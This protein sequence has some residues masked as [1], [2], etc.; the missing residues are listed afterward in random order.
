M[1]QLSIKDVVKKV[2]EKSN[3]ILFKSQLRMVT[4]KPFGKFRTTVYEG[5]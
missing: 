4:T 5:Y 2:I 1:K 3:D